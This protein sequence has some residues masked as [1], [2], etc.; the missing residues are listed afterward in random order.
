M[1]PAPRGSVFRVAA[2]FYLALA[3]AGAIWLAVRRGRFGAE[4]LVD[5]RTLGV[6]LLAGVATAAVLGLAWWGARRLAP[7]AGALERR[8][9]E[10]LG[11][12]DRG[13]IAGLALLSGFAEELFF[14]G[15]VQSSW[16]AVPATVVFALLH[17][18]P[19]REFRLWTGFALVAGGAL[20]ALTAWRGVL[21][22]AMLA[23]ALV[24]AVGLVRLARL[25]PPAGAAGDPA[26]GG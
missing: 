20:A 23:H 24:N 19:G 3:L 17:T 4:I 25:A 15:A 5:R 1:A 26:G 18:G 6:D 2:V 21:L 12:L 8:L 11:P 14:R 16:G 22:P 10:T 9:A 7:S 13:E